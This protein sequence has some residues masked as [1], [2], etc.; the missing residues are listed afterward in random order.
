M[1]HKGLETLPFFS[2][3][4]IAGVLEWA[5]LIDTMER[6]LV[7]LSADEVE[8]P[9]RQMVSV[10]GRNAIIA[11]MPAVGEAMA[12]KVVTLYHDNAGTGLPTH[13]AVIMVFDIANGT[14][15]AV[16][17]GRLI[18]EMRTAAASAA[19]VRALAV[20]TPEIVTIM[21]SRSV[22][23]VCGPGPKHRATP[24]PPISARLFSRMPKRPSGGQISSCAQHRPQNRC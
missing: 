18:T 7:S 6:A 17:D 14:P 24:P 8:Q 10:P 15:L 5:P 4:R 23:C 3:D 9:V 13:Q 2:E 12:V 22:S 19:A 16:M 21:G 1:A 11:A 20:E